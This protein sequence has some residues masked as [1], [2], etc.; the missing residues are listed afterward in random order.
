M[1]QDRWYRIDNVAKVFLASAN[2]RDTRTFRM[3]CTL[4]DEIEKDI[5][6]KA[7]LLALKE[8]PQ[9]HVTILRGLF[10]FYMEQTDD[11]PVVEEEDGRICP[12]LVGPQNFG[13]LHLRVTYY[14][15]RISLEFS[16]AIADGTG[17][18]DFLNLIVEHYLKIRNPEKYEKLSMTSGASEANLAEDSFRKFFVNEKQKIPNMKR[19]PKAYHI[20]GP[21]YPYNQ[22]QYLEVH[23]PV[24]DVLAKAKELNVT[25]TSYIGTI[26]MMAVSN[27]MPM[28]MRGKP[29][30]VSMP[31]NLRNYYPSMTSRNFFNSVLISHVF[32]GGETVEE[33]AAEYQSKLKA[34]LTP[35]AVQARMLN[36][37]KMESL[38]FIRLVPLFIKNPVINMVNKR[39][40][41]EVTLVLSNLGKMSVP[42]AVADEIG[43]YSAYCSTEKLFIVMSTYKDDLVLGISNAYRNTQVLRDFL[44]HFTDADIPVTVYSTEISE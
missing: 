4:K 29:V 6:Q 30:T 28:L 43:S 14:H 44:K 27:D 19:P 5:L 33:L 18:L 23:M 9:Y 20:R 24:K 38:F 40:G 32:K 1:A 7:V 16:H 26:I 25:L 22:T 36:Y 15:N 37:E 35:E 10:W 2:D 12:M 39:A 42:T 13:K 31:V 8:R 3:T 41:K 34:E 21:K 11:L 17:A